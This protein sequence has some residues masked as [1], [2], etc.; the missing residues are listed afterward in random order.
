MNTRNVAARALRFSLVLL[1]AALA[2][3]C[4]WRAAQTS[5]ETAA[6]VRQTA[7]LVPISRRLDD[8]LTHLLNQETGVRGYLATG[9]REHLQTFHYGRRQITRVLTELESLVR[10]EPWYASAVSAELQPRIR[11]LLGTWD[12]LIRQAQAGE[13]GP[14]L[15][16]L[17]AAKADMDDFR[18]H[19]TGITGRAAS[20]IVS[21]HQRTLA[22]QRELRTL[23]Q[24]IGLLAI[25]L[26]LLAAVAGQATE[27]ARAQGQRALHLFAVRAQLAASPSELAEL[28]REQ[29]RLRFAPDDVRVTP[30]LGAAEPEA[31]EA[32]QTRGDEPG[33]CL[34]WSSART[35]MGTG[36]GCDRGC[37]GC[38]PL[39]PGGS[40]LCTPL[41]MGTD[42]L[43]VVRLAHRRGYPW[44]LTEM[45]ALEAYLAVTAPVL[46]NLRLLASARRE[47]LRDPLTGLHNRR[48][49]EEYLPQQL[50]LARREARPCSY[51]ILDLD[52]FKQVN[53]AHG[54]E[55]GDTVLQDVATLLMDGRRGSDAAA[56][57]G[58]EEFVLV[59]P[60][61]PISAAAELAERLR[62]ELE[63]T[64]LR[65]PNGQKLRLTASVGVAEYP[66]DATDPEGLR[67]V[68]DRRL[69]AGKRLGRNRV[70][71]G[72]EPA[73]SLSRPGSP[74]ANQQL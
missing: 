64:E 28:L 4:F 24:L 52:D 36:A 65:L 73:E 43:G 16:R 39:P 22:G 38:G 5:A 58:G 2:V 30:C 6:G 53:D 71:A 54:H 61:T 49:L 31:P 68:A 17:K 20:E 8:L 10:Q 33:S 50:S 66:R 60:S 41:R 3:G 29:L 34:A 35:V 44:S 32:D 45:E 15:S 25:G 11:S 56:R 72:E 48:F 1:V 74:Y 7:T 26:A 19:H 12:A 69:Y 9:D 14:A 55:A 37:S 59:L 70:V 18:R 62:S 67:R 47:A 27:R 13:R 40:H 23:V 63:R 21:V 46:H 42:T 57:Y 51:L